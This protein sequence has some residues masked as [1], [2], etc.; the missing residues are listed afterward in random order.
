MTET[1]KIQIATNMLRAGC[2]KAQVAAALLT[3]TPAGKPAYERT[4]E[5][6]A[7]FVYGYLEAQAGESEKLRAQRQQA[8]N[9]AEFAKAMQ[10]KR[11]AKKASRVVAE[12]Q[13]KSTFEQLLAS[14]K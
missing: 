13:A 8:H 10:A 7:K 2:T 12:A 6:K 5:Q 11:A 4:A 1:Q 14:A 3:S 9:K